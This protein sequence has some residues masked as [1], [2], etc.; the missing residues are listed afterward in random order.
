MR[1]VRYHTRRGRV[2]CWTGVTGRE[3]NALFWA[4][5]A[6]FGSKRELPSSLMSASAGRGHATF[7]DLGC[8]DLG[9]QD[10]GCQDLGCVRGLLDE[11]HT[12]W[13]RAN[14]VKWSIR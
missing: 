9:C 14:D 3:L 1:P 2:G 10:L 4:A 6:R 5:Y 11:Q 7:Q 13:Q 12:C 8:Q